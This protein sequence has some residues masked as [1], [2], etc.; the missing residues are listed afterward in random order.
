ML[1]LEQPQEKVPKYDVP[2][3]TMVRMVKK[4]YSRMNEW[5]DEWM[6]GGMNE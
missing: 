5:M 1:K 2:K 6:N 3:E 4:Q